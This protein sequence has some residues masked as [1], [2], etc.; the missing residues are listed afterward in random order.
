MKKE[1]KEPFDWGIFIV[2]VVLPILTLVIFK[3]IL[4][5]G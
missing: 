5:F 2:V 4:V 3:L 1:P